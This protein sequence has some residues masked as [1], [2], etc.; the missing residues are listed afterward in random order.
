MDLPYELLS[1]IML[2]MFITKAILKKFYTNTLEVLRKVEF[3]HSQKIKSF[4]ES[5]SFYEVNDKEVWVVKK[6]QHKLGL[7]PREIPNLLS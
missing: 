4:V 7:V 6:H 2:L 1:S 3:L 5:W